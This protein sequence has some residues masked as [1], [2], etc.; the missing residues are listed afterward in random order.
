LVVEDQIIVGTHSPVLAE[1][2]DSGIESDLPTRDGFRLDDEHQT[3]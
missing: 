3:W 2:E 1:D